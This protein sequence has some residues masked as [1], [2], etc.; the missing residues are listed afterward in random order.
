MLLNVSGEDLF[1]SLLPFVD[2]AKEQLFVNHVAIHSV[3]AVCCF[4][5][6]KAM[7]I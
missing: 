6:F 2:L 3:E 1:V 4:Y 7:E 5:R